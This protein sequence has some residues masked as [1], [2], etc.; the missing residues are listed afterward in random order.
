MLPFL[1]L[2]YLSVFFTKVLAFKSS[3]IK[4]IVEKLSDCQIHSVN[5]ESQDF[6]DHKNFMEDGF[7]SASNHKNGSV[8][9][10]RNDLSNVENISEYLSQFTLCEN[11]LVMS[12]SILNIQKIVVSVNIS[13]S[14]GIFSYET[15]EFGNVTKIHRMQPL[16]N[17]GPFPNYRR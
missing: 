15:D 3:T 6:K 5:V 7:Y 14:A 11:I 8:L 4:T 17:H 9:T 10:L 2:Y 1:H 16:I 13:I 12:E